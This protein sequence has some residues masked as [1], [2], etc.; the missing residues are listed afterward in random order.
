MKRSRTIRVFHRMKTFKLLALATMLQGAAA[1]YAG[2][3]I[4]ATA[5][6]QDGYPAPQVLY[7]DIVNLDTSPQT[8]T[9]EIMD[10]DGK[11]IGSNMSTVDPNKATASG[12]TSGNG[13]WCRFTINTSSK[14]FRAMA[15]YAGA[16]G[17]TVAVPAQ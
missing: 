9:T 14:K 4:L 1:A 16:S 8:I 15:V 13:A 6:A 5:P 10:F 12:D 3:R 11:V 2:P 7:C 17:Y